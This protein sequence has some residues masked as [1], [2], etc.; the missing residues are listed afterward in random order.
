MR[1]AA[2]DAKC[3][4]L[5]FTPGTEARGNCRLQLEQI[6]ATNNADATARDR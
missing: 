5:G 2:D 4:D 1:R 6:R 3:K